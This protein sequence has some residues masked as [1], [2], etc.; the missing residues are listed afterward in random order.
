MWDDAELDEDENDFEAI[1]EEEPPTITPIAETM[2]ENRKT[3]QLCDWLVLYFLH[4]QTVFHLPDKAMIL[5][6][7]FMS[8]F[9]SVLSK[10]SP[11]CSVIAMKF[12]K[13]LLR[14]YNKERNAFTKYV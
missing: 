13:T 3:S 7:L 5:I 14:K 1:I 11:T 9:F 4:L 12:P 10:I 6:L 8:T 2:E